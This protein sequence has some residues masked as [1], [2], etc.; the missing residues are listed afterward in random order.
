MSP[1][2]PRRAV[3]IAS[4]ALL[5][6]L[7]AACGDDADDGAGATTTSTT[8]SPEDVKVPLAD[9]VAGLPALESG[10]ADAATAAAAGDFQAA[11]D[12]YDALHELWEGIEGTLKDTDPD[13]YEAI[14]TAQGLMRD[15]AENE[16]AGRVADGAADQAAAIQAFI[17]ANA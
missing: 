14:E 9:V 11:I 7:G 10:G 5:G 1:T 3:A 13:A 15:G 4:V 12:A 17:A 6:M 16:N 2:T 8:L